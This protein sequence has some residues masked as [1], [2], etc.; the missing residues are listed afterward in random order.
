MHQRLFGL[1]GTDIGALG[2]SWSVIEPVSVRL[3]F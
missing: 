1:G 2:Q 3:M